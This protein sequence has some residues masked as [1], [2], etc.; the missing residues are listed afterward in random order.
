VFEAHRAAGASSSRRSLP[1]EIHCSRG[2]DVT[3]TLRARGTLLAT[4]RETETEITRPYAAISLPLSP[5]SIRLL[6][7]AGVTADFAA[8]DAAGDLRSQ[9]LRLA[10][11]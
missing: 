10:G 9:R 1:L 11:R 8:S 7:H 5:A 4:Y 2:C 6:D 3:I